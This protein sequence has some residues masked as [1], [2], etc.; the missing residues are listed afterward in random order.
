VKTEQEIRVQIQKM[1]MVVAD[2]ER[3]KTPHTYEQ[4]QKFHKAQR[5]IAALKWVL[6]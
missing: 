5:S 4:V 3:Q 2:I 6:E 1:E